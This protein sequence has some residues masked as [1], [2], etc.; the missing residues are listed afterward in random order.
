MAKTKNE[1]AKANP[2]FIVRGSSG[3]NR[4]FFGGSYDLSLEPLVLE[5][6]YG[7][8]GQILEDSFE[9]KRI[10]RAKEAV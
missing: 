5:V 6:Q 1:L 8:G 7:P 4:L 10:V 3:R 2:F 9:I